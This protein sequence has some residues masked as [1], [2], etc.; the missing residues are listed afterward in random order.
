MLVFILFYVP[1]SKLGIFILIYFDLVVTIEH[2][3]IIA[4]K[5]VENAVIQN[6][7]IISTENAKMGVTVV[8]KV[9]SVMRVSALLIFI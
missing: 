4:A 6:N 1:S 5:L 8:T 7:V 9:T 3:E 2:M